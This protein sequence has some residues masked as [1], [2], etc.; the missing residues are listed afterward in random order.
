MMILSIFA[1]NN[2]F[3]YFLEYVFFNFIWKFKFSLLKKII[4]KKIIG[5]HF[6]CINFTF[7]T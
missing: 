1:Y 6:K 5:K 3:K 4:T 7:S 2:E